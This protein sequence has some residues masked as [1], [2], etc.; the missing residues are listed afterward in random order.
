MGINFP[1]APG[2]GQVYPIT[3]TP[4]LPQYVW[5][6]TAWVLKSDGLGPT[7]YVSDTAP[8]GAIDGALWWDSTQGILYLRYFDGDSRAW[9]QCAPSAADYAALTAYTDR[10]VLDADTNLVINGGLE[11][12][13]EYGAVAQTVAH[14]A[15]KYT[16]D[17]WHVYAAGNGLLAF[18]QRSDSVLPVRGFRNSLRLYANPTAYNMAGANDLISLQQ[19]IEGARAARLGFGGAGALPVTI[20]FWVW[21]TIPGTKTAGIRNANQNHT[22]LTPVTTGTSTWEYKFFT[23]PGDVAGTWST[24]GDLWAYLAFTFGSGSAFT[25]TANAWQANGAYAVTGTT[26]FFASNSNQILI[27]GVSMVPGSIGPSAAQSPL[28]MRQYDSDLALCLRYWERGS[29]RLTYYNGSGFAGIANAYDTVPFLVQ[30]RIVPTM[31]V[32]PGGTFQYY[33]TA[34]GF[35]NVTPT[36]SP[37]INQMIYFGSAMTNWKAWTNSGLWAASARM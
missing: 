37:L 35:V 19:P 26:N 16:V 25:T 36:F 22:Y 34:D 17:Q 1:N 2:I 24:V 13:Q 28:V 31:S 27:T 8:T 23:I 10:M 9:V 12:S 7:I 4:G 3:P 5:D 20:G 21:T 14:G 15:F 29:Q 33:N 18:D 32:L 6:G 30:K 11:V